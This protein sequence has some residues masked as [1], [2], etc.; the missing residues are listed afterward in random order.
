MQPAAWGAYMLKYELDYFEAEE[1][2]VSRLAV[3]RLIFHRT[4]RAVL[5][6]GYLQNEGF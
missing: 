4:G 1:Y 2:E 3:E 6:G 5:F